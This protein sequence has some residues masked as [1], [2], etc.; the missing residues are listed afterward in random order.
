MAMLQTY[1]RR[2]IE[3]EHD[4]ALDLGHYI[5]ILR[6]RV[7]FF[8][9][10]FV[11]LL[12][13]GFLISAIQRPIYRA[14][15]KILVEPQAIPTDLVE[16][17]VTAPPT[18]RIKVIE[19]RITSRDTLLPLVT[20]FGLFAPEQRWMS[21]TELLDLMR[22]RVEIQLVDLDTELSQGK[23][24]KKPAAPHPISKNPAIAF[25]ISFDYET[26]ELAVKVAN[27][28]L[29]TILNEDIR[30]R[31]DRATE[32]TQFLDREVKRLQADLDSINAQILEMKR[33]AQIYEL[34]DTDDSTQGNTEKLKSQMAALT[35][36]KADLIQK[37]S[38][39]SDDHPAVKALKKKIAAL[40]LEISSAPKIDSVRPQVTNI[41]ILEQQRTSIANN[42]DDANK[43]LTAA[44]L[45]ES[46]E[47][48]QQSEP[49][50]V[51]EQPTL[52]Q[53]PIRP[54]RLKLFAI[55]FALATMVGVGTVLLAE[56]SDKSIRGTR[57]LAGLVDSHLVVTIP[58]IAT[59]QEIG[60]KK[61][62]IILLWLVLA[63]VLFAGLAAA[64]Y[65]GTQ[66]DFSWFD[67]PWIDPLT[68]LSK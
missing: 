63:V 49:L 33:N 25:T 48:N 24:A 44:R 22:D 4:E 3:S 12:I 31:T 57:E 53:Q 34:K 52:P 45:G 8:A 14:E 7:F 29:T 20:K 39:Y 36:M 11:F 9:I 16:P 5:G 15:G 55:S 66:I 19:Q 60:Q 58:Y 38:I 47:R 56:M 43:K 21:G 30:A 46:M 32:T 42:L 17:T 68:R 62:R 51:I 2:P 18:E 13:F 26:P 1:P 50:L 35:A 37:A 6:K 27:D 23:D 40:E 10:P 64:L 28:F 54:K 65:I 61:R 41:D 59:V 67:K